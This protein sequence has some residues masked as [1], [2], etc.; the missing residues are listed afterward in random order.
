MGAVDDI[1]AL[2][3][4]CRRA[5]RRGTALW[6]C[7]CARRVIRERY[8]PSRPDLRPL[9]ALDGLRQFLRTSVPRFS[10]AAQLLGPALASV[11]LAEAEFDDEA[12]AASVIVAVLALRHAIAPREAPPD[13]VAASCRDHMVPWTSRDPTA[14]RLWEER[15]QARRLLWRLRMMPTGGEIFVRLDQAEYAGVLPRA[16]TRASRRYA[17]LRERVFADEDARLDLIL[18]FPEALFHAELDG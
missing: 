5:E 4:L 13:V 11:E 2:A 6:I 17:E 16:G 7:D 10:A 8:Q 14:L 3:Q 18:E 9:T 12:E 15:W 1:L